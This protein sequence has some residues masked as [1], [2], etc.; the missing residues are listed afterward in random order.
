MHTHHRLLSGLQ[1]LN[2]SKNPPYNR[3]FNVFTTPR[4]PPEVISCDL[5]PCRHSK[6]LANGIHSIISSTTLLGTKNACSMSWRIFTSFKKNY[7]RTCLLERWCRNLTDHHLQTLSYSV[8][9]IEITL[10]ISNTFTNSASKLISRLAGTLITTDS[11]STRV[12]FRSCATWSQSTST[13]VHIYINTSRP[14]TMTGQQHSRHY[15]C[16]YSQP[17][18]NSCTELWQ[19]ITVYANCPQKPLCVE[20]LTHRTM[21]QPIWILLQLRIWL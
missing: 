6:R 17:T 10:L 4:S 8:W 1:T 15:R 3:N 7:H 14:H 20:R 16:C 2:H 21:T 13:L 11:V 18:D 5:R 19:I 12:S 9:D